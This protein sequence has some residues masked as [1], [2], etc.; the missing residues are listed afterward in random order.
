[1]DGQNRRMVSSLTPLR[2]FEN[3]VC[4]VR[5]TQLVDASFDRVDASSNRSV[6]F[7]Q[8]VE[9]L[10]Y[11]PL[12]VLVPGHLQSHMVDVAMHVKHCE[13]SQHIRIACRVGESY[14]QLT[15]HSLAQLATY[16]LALCAGD[17]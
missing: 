4:A 6:D 7:A 11:P 15:T 9:L 17:R 14:I 12:T 13:V 5:I 16:S 3:W 8:F 1:M 2:V 10:C